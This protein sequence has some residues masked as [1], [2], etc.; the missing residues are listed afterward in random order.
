VASE[1][2][3]HWLKLYGYKLPA[4]AYKQ[5]ILFGANPEV[6]DALIRSGCHNL[7]VADDRLDRSLVSCEK[8]DGVLAEIRAKESQ[9]FF[10]ACGVASTP[11]QRAKAIKHIEEHL[12]GCDN[13]AWTNVRA[14]TANLS[15]SATLGK[16]VLVL[17]ECYVGPLV[18]LQD[19]SVLLPGAKI[20]HHGLVESYSILVG[21]CTCLGHSMVLTGSR[22]CGNAVVFPHAMLGPGKTAPA[23]TAVPAE[24]TSAEEFLAEFGRKPE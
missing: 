1:D 2:I 9:S 18:E 16:G 10:L 13:W 17:D 21:G 22:V 5:T 11:M 23:L 14:A 4:K 12:H 19:H 3:K 8:W 20:Y 7:R 6:E 15:P 24:K